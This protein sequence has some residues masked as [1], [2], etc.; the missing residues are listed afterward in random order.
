M[1]RG[2][3]AAEVDIEDVE[4][5]KK[6]ESRAL[7]E[8]KTWKFRVHCIIRGVAWMV[9]GHTGVFVCGPRH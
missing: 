7:D 9:T 2:G 1:A 5:K 3:P 4:Q 6:G 8:S